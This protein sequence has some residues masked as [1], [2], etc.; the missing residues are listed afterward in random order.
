MG[1]IP[2]RV[3]KKN[4]I[5]T[6]IRFFLFLVTS[7]LGIEPTRATACSAISALNSA[8]FARAQ[9]RELGSNLCP[10]VSRRDLEGW[11]RFPYKTSRAQCSRGFRHPSLR[12][13][14]GV[15]FSFLVPVRHRTQRISQRLNAHGD[16]PQPRPSLW[17][18]CKARVIPVQEI[19]PGDEVAEFATSPRRFRV[20]SLAGRSKFPY[21]IPMGSTSSGFFF[22]FR[23]AVSSGAHASVTID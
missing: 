11:G 17:E 23:R 6:R 14:F 13:S 12:R 3:T 1:S 22:T 18:A 8:R 15:F 2:V 10:I 16:E 9:T 20:G 7:Y 4:L 21:K 5:R 19:S